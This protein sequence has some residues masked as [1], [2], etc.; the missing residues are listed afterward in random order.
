MRSFLKVAGCVLVL[1]VGAVLLGAWLSPIDYLPTALH[2]WAK[3]AI[4]GN[5]WWPILGAEWPQ[6]L[7]IFP[8][9]MEHFIRSFWINTVLAF[10]ILLM[11]LLIARAGIRRIRPWV[12]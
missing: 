8:H 4:Y 12:K 5:I 6:G 9:S 11:A 10:A 1:V 2:P 3:R 7:L